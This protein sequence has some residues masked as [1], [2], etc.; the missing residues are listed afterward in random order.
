MRA[1]RFL[2]CVGAA[3]LAGFAACNLNLDHSLIGKNRDAGLEG[4]SGFDGSGGSEGSPGTGGSSGATTEGG[5]CSTAA[6]CTAGG[7][8]VEGRCIGGHCV[9]ETCP[10]TAACTARSCNT[11]SNTCGS[12]QTYGFIAG[13]IDVGQDLAC[14]GS[15]SRCLAAMG[16][17][18]FVGTQNGL[19][20]WR[21]TDPISPQKVQVSQPPFSLEIQE[22]VADN[23]RVLVLGP[24]RN[25]QLSLAWIDLPSDPNATQINIS[26]A[27]VSFDPAGFSVAYPANSGAFF[28]VRNDSGSSYPSYRLSLPIQNGASISLYPCTG[29]PTG[30]T[31]IGSSGSRLVTFRVDTTNSP[32]AEFSLEQN[33]GTASAQNAGETAHSEAG[34]VSTNLG[35][36]TFASGYD[37][38]LLWSTN[39]LT[40]QDGGGDQAYAVVFRWPLVGT[41]TTFKANR[42]VTLESYP[43]FG[44]DT[45]Y[46]GPS[47]LIDPTTALATAADPVNL[48]QATDVY[49]VTRSGDTLTLGKGSGQVPAA[50]YQIGVAG[51]STFGYVLTPSTATAPATPNPTLHIFAPSCN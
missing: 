40:P 51:G 38:S 4:S 35:A 29:I 28:L 26:S 44:P 49:S 25:G 8:C 16:D 7:G 22:L 11:T 34:D 48:Q 17:Y 14:G 10:T 5:T 27:V 31:V 37:G 21:V 18:V 30:S 45:T 9:Y 50:V 12:P 46:A 15:T 24:D 19:S 33:A 42:Q 41:A 6:D 20:A 36:H 13:T 2:A 43:P 39:H 47:A 1:A 32:T 3:M 23:S